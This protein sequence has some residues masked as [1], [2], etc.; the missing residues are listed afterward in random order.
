MSDLPLFDTMMV[1]TRIDD[2]QTSHDA[3][4]RMLSVSG[5]QCKMIVEVLRIFR[6]HG[7]TADEI[8]AELNRQ[9]PEEREPWSN[10]R[11]SRRLSAIRDAGL[12]VTYDG[13]RRGRRSYPALIRSGQ[14]V[15]VASEYSK[16]LAA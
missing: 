16:S 13:K 11:V 4:E 3:A 1:R 2:P 5:R 9:Y 6:E 15:H 7:A 8:A 12:I 10:V 14:A